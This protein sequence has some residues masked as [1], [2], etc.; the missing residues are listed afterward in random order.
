MSAY[1]VKRAALV[2]LLGALALGAGATSLAQDLP[3]P[4]ASVQKELDVKGISYN[5]WLLFHGIRERN[6]DY[7]N[8]AFRAGTDLSKARNPIGELSA[9]MLAVSGQNASP[10]IVGILIQRGADVNARWAPTSMCEKAD[11]T[12]SQRAACQAPGG[13][14]AAGSFPLYQAALL[15]NP[16]VVEQLLKSGADVRAR[17]RNG[18]TALHATFDMGIADVLLRYGADINA[19][20]TNGLTPLGNARRVLSHYERQPSDPMRQKVQTYA[21]WLRAQGAQ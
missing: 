5:E 12:P 15:G 19:K 3:K 6:V 18:N 2:A 20:N 1:V 10:K 7:V 13:P 8:A 9:V 14:Q 16:D 4:T 11:L 17:A 21:S